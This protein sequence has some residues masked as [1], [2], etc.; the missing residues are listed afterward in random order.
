M[1]LKELLKDI[2]VVAVV[3]SE[4]IEITGVNIE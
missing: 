1:K 3:G 2:P 4:D